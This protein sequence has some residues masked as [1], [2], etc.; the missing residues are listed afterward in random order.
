MTQGLDLALPGAVLP[1][2]ARS[3]ERPAAEGSRSAALVRAA[4][5]GDREAFGELYRLYGR[6]V[7][8]VLLSLLPPSD[9]P[10]LAQEVFLQALRRLST[11]RDPEAFG[12]W[13][14]ALARNAA[15]DHYRRPAQRAPR[16]ELD[17]NLEA[18][19]VPPGQAAEALAVLAAIRALPRAY[20]ETLTLRL[21]EGMTGP[22]IAA[23]TGLTP[24][25]VRVNLHRGMKKLRLKLGGG[26]P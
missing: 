17:D 12:G 2:A 4:R 14:A 15:R 21:I 13:L 6:L 8:G 1:H 24:E 9:V 3:G 23:Q 20:R 16:V 19:A 10:D 26:A 22:E 7:H 11:L 5:D 25:S 18:A